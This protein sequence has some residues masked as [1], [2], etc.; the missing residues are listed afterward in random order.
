MHEAEAS[1]RAHDHYEKACAQLELATKT[2]SVPDWKGH[3]E[4]AKAEIGLARLALELGGHDD[5]R[6]VK[7]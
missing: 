7:L 2:N 3:T 4:Q 5:T 1:N 6:A